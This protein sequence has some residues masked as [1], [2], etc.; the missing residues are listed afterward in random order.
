[1]REGGQNLSGKTVGIIGC[2]N[3]GQEVIKL[4]KPFGCNILVN[5]IEDKN[6]FCREQS[7]I[8][9]SFEILINESDIVSLHVPLTNLTREL[10]DENILQ[11]MKPTAFLI[12]TSRGSVVKHS[13]LH[14]ALLSGK[15]SGAALDVFDLE[16][17]DDLKFLRLPNL[18]VTPHIGGKSIE[19][20]EAMGTAAID[21]LAKFFNK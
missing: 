18:M 7:A 3:V 8:E 4:L 11:A 6:E 9:S 1:I 5:D 12:N 14:E 21:N 2:G 16:P 10:V 15:I 20:I 17:P 19:A 13:A